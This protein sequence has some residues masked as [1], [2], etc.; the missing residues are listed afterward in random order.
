MN[1]RVTQMCECF[2]VSCFRWIFFLGQ[3][4]YNELQIC[5]TTGRPMVRCNAG[6]SKRCNSFNM[7]GNHSSKSLSYSDNGR[8]PFCSFPRSPSLHKSE[9]SFVLLRFYGRETLVRTFPLSGCPT[10]TA[11]SALSLNNRMDFLCMGRKK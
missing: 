5:F 9:S 7:G 3:D 6:M 1:Q 4:T 2:C 10:P 8:T 11:I